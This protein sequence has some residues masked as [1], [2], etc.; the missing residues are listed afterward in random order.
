MLRISSAP[1]YA[2]LRIF[3]P[4]LG[5]IWCCCGPC[6]LSCANLKPLELHYTHQASATPWF[7]GKQ[8]SGCRYWPSG[9]DGCRIQESRVSR[10]HKILDIK[11]D[12]LVKLFKCEESPSAMSHI[13]IAR[14]GGDPWIFDWSTWL[15]Q[16]EIASRWILT[17]LA[18]FTWA[19][20]HQ[21]PFFG[22]H[23]ARLLKLSFWDALYVYCRERVLEG[24]RCA[25][26]NRGWG[27][28]LRL[29]HTP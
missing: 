2:Y 12:E 19:A 25:P 18:I 26:I 10:S 8:F 6:K 22:I 7:L 15:F 9:R 20:H 16:C 29:A 23:S 14:P 24:D 3:S 5:S 11:L 27:C 13:K 4:N 17:F 1:N 21:P 28:S